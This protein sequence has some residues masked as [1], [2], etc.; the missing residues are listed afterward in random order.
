VLSVFLFL[1]DNIEINAKQALVVAYQLL[2]ILC[3]L[4]N[5]FKQTNITDFYA[6]DID[7]AELI[8]MKIEYLHAGER[9]KL[10]GQLLQEV[11]R[12]IQFDEAS[13][14][15][16]GCKLYRFDIGARKDEKFKRT[17]VFDE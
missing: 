15:R 2:T 12:Q 5:I 3:R 11:T 14:F 9:A 4:Y 7:A 16:D 13:T 8:I 1:R 6:S 10:E 17:W